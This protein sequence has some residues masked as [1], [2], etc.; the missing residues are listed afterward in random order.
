MLTPLSFRTAAAVS[1]LQH[2]FSTPVHLSTPARFTP[3]TSQYTPVQ[4][5]KKNNIE[6]PFD[7]LEMENLLV[8][9]KLFSY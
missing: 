8:K 5:D 1:K 7:K 9:L 2:H 4:G 6:G 3:P